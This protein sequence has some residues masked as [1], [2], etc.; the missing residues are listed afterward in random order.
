VQQNC[1]EASE[2]ATKK[3]IFSTGTPKAPHLSHQVVT[4]RFEIYA[5]TL[6]SE[7]KVNTYESN[8]NNNNKKAIQ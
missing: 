7:N 3:E 4:R 8:T 1:G 2:S 5:A 6:G